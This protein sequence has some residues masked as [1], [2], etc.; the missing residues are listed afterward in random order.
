MPVGCTFDLLY[1]NVSAIPANLGVG[2]AITVTLYKNGSATTM[3]AS[4]DSSVPSGGNAKGQSVSVIA[5][6][7]IALRATGAGVS[8][9]QGTI[10]ASLHCQ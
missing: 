9:G 3:A 8:T 5:G 2:G 1:V 4:G 6:D 10:Q 7:L